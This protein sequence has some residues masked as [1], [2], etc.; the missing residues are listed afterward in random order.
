[1]MMVAGEASGDFLGSELL[2]ELK[3]RFPALEAK[4]VGGPRMRLAGFETVADMN[5]LSI[6]GLV[7]V[8]KRLPDL[9]RILRALLRLMDDFRPSVLVTIDLPDFNFL[10]ARF[11][12]KRGIKIVHYVS[13]QIWAWR[14]GRV[15]KIARL[16]DHLLV[17][18]P[19]EPKYYAETGLPVTFVGHPLVKKPPPQTPREAVRRE[20]GVTG[21]DKLVVLLAGSRHS[22]LKR[23]FADIVGT[24]AR[25]AA[26]RGGVRFALALAPS[27]TEADIRAHWPPGIDVDIAIIPDRNDD[28]IAAADA[29]L[30]VSGTVTL[31]AALLGAPMVVIYRGARM[32]Y[33]IGKRLV[34][35]PNF[36]LANLVAEREVAPERLQDEVTPEILE[37]DLRRI[38]DEPGVGEGMRS[39]WA[40]MR[41]N[42]GH[43]PK[44]AGEVVT[45]YLAEEG[46]RHAG[47]G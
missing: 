18:F 2:N 31:E 15:H 41:E 6:I 30:A 47:G 14:S 1:M 21:E 32:T 16:V 26:E 4:G 12:R 36:A 35:I 13:P 9:W 3:Q 44:S 17:L 37:A 25:L 8:I 33:L 10:L 38:L 43:P 45:E 42:L 34:K 39:A 28:L 23:L 29:V 24:C 40:A 19:F 7:E 27:L 22:E 20:L 5:A 11:A 46:G